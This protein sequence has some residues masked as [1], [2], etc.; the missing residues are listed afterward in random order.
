MV[1]QQENTIAAIGLTVAM[2]LLM[3]PGMTAIS[4]IKAVMHGM[5]ALHMP[6]KERKAL[7]QIKEAKVLGPSLNG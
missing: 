6:V 3:Q 5:D 4:T 7:I 2:V 1:I